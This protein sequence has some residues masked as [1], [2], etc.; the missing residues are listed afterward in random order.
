M[1]LWWL[2]GGEMFVIWRVWVVVVEELVGCFLVMLVCGASWWFHGGADTGS[3]VVVLVVVF[4]VDARGGWCWF[5]VVTLVVA[6][7]GFW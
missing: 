4:G 2:G 1:G 6:G 5:L 7:A 3:F